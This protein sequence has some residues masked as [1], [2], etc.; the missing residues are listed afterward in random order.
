SSTCLDTVAYGFSI[1]FS[2]HRRLK[3][4]TVVGG[5]RAA[6]RLQGISHGSLFGFIPAVNIEWFGMTG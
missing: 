4:V 1:N 2:L 3:L 5:K 6:S